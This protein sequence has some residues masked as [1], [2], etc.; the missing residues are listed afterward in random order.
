MTRVSA[1][2]QQDL[3]PE[4]LERYARQMGPAVLSHA[5][6]SRLKRSAALVTRVGGMGGPAA[7]C[8]AMAGVGRVVIAHG[9][10]MIVPDLNRQLLGSEAV[11]GKPRAPHFAE[12]L[13][14]MNHHV[15]VHAI[16][17]E[18]SPTEARELA[19]DV[20][21]ILACPPTFAE[22]ML[23]NEAAV[24]A[25]KPLIDAAQWGM[26]GSLIVVDPGHTACLRC[27]YP[28]EPEFEEFFP[29]VGA[30]SSAIGSLA[31]L[32]AIK[33]LSGTGQSMAGRMLMFDGYDSRTRIMDLQRDAKCPVCG[34]L[35]REPREST[36][37]D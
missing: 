22:R 25:G 7:L 32:E 27:I 31:A 2:T 35:S 10:P 5:G 29:V 4:E 16:D 19:A 36:S 26:M 14:A 28:R 6:Q 11:I 12:T 3:S 34:S 15:E 13:R 8:L 20:D 30:I 18:P 21:I 37:V 23:L 17:H 1:I 24:A 33:M 9:G